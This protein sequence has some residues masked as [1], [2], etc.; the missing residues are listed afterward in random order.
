[1]GSTATTT[2]QDERQQK[3]ETLQKQLRRTIPRTR[4]AMLW[5]R[6]YPR[7]IPAVGL[8]AVFT[9]A[10]CAGALLA[11]PLEA[12][13]ASL[14]LGG[15]A[16][17]ASLVLPLRHITRPTREQAIERIDET[18]GLPHQPVNTLLAALPA[19]PQPAPDTVRLWTEHQRATA[20]KIEKFSTGYRHPNLAHTDPYGLRLM[21]AVTLALGLA[22]GNVNSYGNMMNT[23]TDWSRPPVPVEPPPPVIPARVDIWVEKPAYTGEGYDL[24]TVDGVIRAER[25]PGTAVTVPA[26]SVMKITVSGG[27]S[28]VDINGGAAM[29]KEPAAP[30]PPVAGQPAAP[31]TNMLQEY[32]VLLTQE[33]AAVT[34]AATGVGS[35][36]WTFNITPDRAPTVNLRVEPDPRREGR[37]MVTMEVNEDYRIEEVVP[38][39]A[40][41]APKVTTRRDSR[42]LIPPPPIKLPRP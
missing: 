18:T 14:A 13:A 38:E 3:L 19:V 41:T 36:S 17:L 16:L 12:R 39:M 15:M 26:G 42:P 27:E 35:L 31:T 6:T 30:L 2:G 22:I 24:F 4:A 33:T 8:T 29:Q 40:P 25:Q 23:L 20:A 11:L 5:E 28:A 9:G 7:L 37:N 21:A 1:M 32:E 34:V 10:V